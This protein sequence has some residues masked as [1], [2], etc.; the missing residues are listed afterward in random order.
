M[1]RMLDLQCR[2]CGAEV[3]DMLFR[4]VP[5]RIRH[6]FCGGL[7]DQVYRPSRRDA[8][9]S[10]KDAVVVFRK[11][12]GSI[13]YPAVNS[14]ATPLGCERIELR[15]MAAVRQFE[16]AHNVVAHIAHFDQGSGRSIDD[17]LP[18]PLGR[19]PSERERYERFRESTRGIF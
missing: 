4:E 1:M 14:K 7:M 2:R 17:G 13:S 9:W 3:T 15:S 5:R 12:D 8:Q 18:N 10:P 6:M 19:L 16:R 11:P